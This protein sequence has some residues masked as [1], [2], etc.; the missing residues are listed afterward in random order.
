MPIVIV[1]VVII[2]FL[3]IFVPV[4][5]IPFFIILVP[6]FIVVVPSFVITLVLVDNLALHNRR[7]SNRMRLAAIGAV[8]AFAPLAVRTLVPDPCQECTMYGACLFFAFGQL[9]TMAKR[10]GIAIERTCTVKPL[11]AHVI[12]TPI[13]LGFTV[14]PAIGWAVSVDLDGR[15][16]MATATLA[17]GPTTAFALFAFSALSFTFSFTLSFAFTFSFATPFSF[18]LSFSFLSFS[19]TFLSFALS[20]APFSFTFSFSALAFALARHIVCAVVWVIFTPCSKGL[21]SFNY[22][23]VMGIWALLT[24]K[25]TLAIDHVLARD[26]LE[27]IRRAFLL[28]RFLWFLLWARRRFLFGL[29]TFGLG[30]GFGFRALALAF[31]LFLLFLKLTFLPGG[32]RSALLG[33]KQNIPLR[34]PLKLPIDLFLTLFSHV[35]FHNGKQVLVA[36]VLVVRELLEPLVVLDVPFNG[37]E[38][39]DCVIVDLFGLRLCQRK[40]HT[41]QHHD[42]RCLEESDVSVCDLQ[43]HYVLQLV[44]L[45]ILI[46][47]LHAVTDMA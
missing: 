19:F 22:H 44:E 30:L 37:F 1:P 23:R 17:P 46:T 5:L 29:L 28:S 2:P 43:V 38:L 31:G 39:F 40:P 4:I 16:R 9:R 36:P 24:W 6:L 41:L 45:C 27:R 12:L 8:A 47:A 18:A 10:T 11:T 13:P 32:Q 34:A 42:P 35:P 21:G 26:V 3:I 33:I 14:F 20:L 15:G 7:A 25:L